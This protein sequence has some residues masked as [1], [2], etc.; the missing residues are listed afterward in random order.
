[1][2]GA[3]SSVTQ[4][5]PRD[6]LN[7]ENWPIAAGMLQF[8][9]TRADGK[10][11]QLLGAPEWA[12][13]FDEVAD[14]G[15]DNVEITDTWLRAGDLNAQELS[16]LAATAAHYGLSVPAVALIRRSV[17]DRDYGSVNLAYSHRSI[18]AAA[19][20]G[21]T[22][23]SVGLHEGLSDDQKRALWF[24]TADG[25]RN[26]RLDPLVWDAAT[27]YF[28]A[29]GQHAA[30][31]GVLLSLELYED[32]LLGTADD[33]VRLVE[34][35]DLPEVGLNLDLGNLIRLHRPVEPWEEILQK[36]LPYTNYWHVK[37]YQRDEDPATGTYFAVPTPL[38]LGIINYRKALKDA[39]SV[40]F[41]GVITC[42]HYGGDGLS[43]SATNRDY[44]RKVL[45]KTTPT[46]A[47][48][49]GTRP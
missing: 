18:D 28:R 41:A 49:E 35:I 33:A 20:L 10:S 29:L 11:V 27:R 45:P 39:V 8:P 19:A 14:A 48:T 25:A 15:F 32:T 38:E 4:S 5:Y 43:V 6:S 3:P 22:I 26:D 16:E 47:T 46:A 34:T 31:V 23:V 1:M 40:G 36:A 37:N 2:T 42:E 17:L 24:W 7:R 13:A 30:E 44:L 21:A 12:R 9:A